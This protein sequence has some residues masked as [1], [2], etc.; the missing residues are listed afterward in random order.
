M[1]LRLAA[2]VSGRHGH[3]AVGVLHLERALRLLE[4]A[5]SSPVDVGTTQ[6]RMSEVLLRIPAQ[7]ARARAMAEAARA[8]FV[9]AGKA[10]APALA[11]L[12]AYLR[13]QGWR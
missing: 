10:G 5:K 1:G 12:D 9:T 8:S 4:R 13:K 7:R 6:Q 3:A 2:D 11:E